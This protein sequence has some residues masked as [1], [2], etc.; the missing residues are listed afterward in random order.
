MENV[1]AKYKDKY[2]DLF[3]GNIDIERLYKEYS[4]YGAN[5]ITTRKTLARNI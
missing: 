2:L 3:V 1:L 4:G 5:S